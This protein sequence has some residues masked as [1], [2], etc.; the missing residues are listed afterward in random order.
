MF[1]SADLFHRQPPIWKSP[2]QVSADHDSPNHN[3]SSHKSHDHNSPDHNSRDH[4]S[5]VK[6]VQNSLTDQVFADHDN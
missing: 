2:N 1:F 4:N 3:S 6:S 5:P